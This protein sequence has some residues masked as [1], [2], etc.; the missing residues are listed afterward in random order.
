MGPWA[1]LDRVVIVSRCLH[2]RHASFRHGPFSGL[3]F[4]FCVCVHCKE[5]QSNINMHD[6][7]RE[8]KVLTGNH[9]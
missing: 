6:L 4:K 7:H 5:K 3:S 9:L 1:A 8:N 2:F